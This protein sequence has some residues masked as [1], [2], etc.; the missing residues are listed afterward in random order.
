MDSSG[1]PLSPSDAAFRNELALI[2]KNGFCV[3]RSEVDDGRVGIAVPIAIP[4][5]AL[6]AS[7]SLVLDAAS[8]NESIENRLV[9]LLVSSA[10]LIKDQLVPRG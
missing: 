1:Q 9:L 7:L 5:Q 8:S 3:A 4:E 2:R 6:V 10:A